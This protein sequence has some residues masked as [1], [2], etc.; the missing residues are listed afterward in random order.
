MSTLAVV[1]YR[2]KYYYCIHT[3]HSLWFI[4]Q[5]LFMLEME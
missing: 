1:F 5:I 3:I 2:T 4:I